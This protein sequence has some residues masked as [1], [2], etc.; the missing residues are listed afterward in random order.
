[1]DILGRERGEVE[2]GKKGRKMN[3][4]LLPL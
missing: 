3:T 1:M 2:K 4:Y